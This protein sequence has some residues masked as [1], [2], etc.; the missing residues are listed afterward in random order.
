MCKRRE[1]S[2]TASNC[3]VCLITDANTGPL[4]ALVCGL[5]QSKK[6]QYASHIVM[7]C[8]SVIQYTVPH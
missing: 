2:M 3:R 8:V 4:V 7:H 6:L 5:F 1:I